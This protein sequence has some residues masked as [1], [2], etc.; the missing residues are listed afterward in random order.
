MDEFRASTTVGLPED[1]AATLTVLVKK[2]GQALESKLRGTAKSLVVSLTTQLQQAEE[3]TKQ[4]LAADNM[5]TLRSK[6][7]QIDNLDKLSELLPV[8][9]SAECKVLHGKAKIL[10]MF[11]AEKIGI[12]EQLQPLRA[13]VEEDMQHLLIDAENLRETREK[14]LILAS[15]QGLCRPLKEGETRPALARRARAMAMS[16]P[17]VNLPANLN[18]LLTRSAAET[19]KPRAS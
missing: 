7:E 5:K 14:H 19:P 18:M 4:A 16:R 6:L 15:I 2:V 17:D 11:A 3:A 8:A 12:V 10:D 1:Q 9:T 13:L